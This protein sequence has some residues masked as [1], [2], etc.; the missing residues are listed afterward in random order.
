MPAV[1]LESPLQLEPLQSEPALLEPPLLQAIVQE[2][3]GESVS[4]D[5]FERKATAAHSLR[6]CGSRL[7]GELSSNPQ[8]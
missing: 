3:R 7:T 2:T 8:C 6:D 4:D 1:S 5:Q